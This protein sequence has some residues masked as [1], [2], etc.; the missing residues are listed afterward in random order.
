MSTRPPMI[1]TDI[2]IIELAYFL[3]I[4]LLGLSIYLHTRKLQNFSFH[5]GIKYFRNAFF[6]FSLIYFFR[7]FVLTLQLFLPSLS[8]DWEV[9]LSQLSMYLITFFS[10]FAI[11]CLLASF[12]WKHYRFISDNR[13]ALLS[14]VASSAT[15][16]LKLPSILFA[17]SIAGIAIL[18]YSLIFRKKAR[19]KALSSIFPIYALLLIFF[20]F[21][22]VPLVQEITPIWLE[23]SGY[24]GS[25]IIFVYLNLKIK[26][27]FA[28]GEKEKK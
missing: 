20:L 3:A 27:V 1:P 12:L 4:A 11:F 14:L 21:D 26:R 28:S 22:L 25:I 6:S 8:A 24:I 2:V 17:V 9:T 18:L 16:F 19:K 23:V 15:Y 10:F 7:L 13:L 5:R